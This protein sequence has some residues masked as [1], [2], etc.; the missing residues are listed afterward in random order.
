MVISSTL[1]CRPV[2]TL[3][4][5][6]RRVPE[7]SLARIRI[8]SRSDDGSKMKWVI[9]VLAFM[10]LVPISAF[11]LGSSAELEEQVTARPT[12]TDGDGIEDSADACPDG[13]TGWTSGSG[14]DADGDG[15]KDQR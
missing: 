10:L 3:S 2:D 4:R 9:A 5:G 7:K 15:C 14:N 6:T 8:E 11:F 1:A 13:E 12:D